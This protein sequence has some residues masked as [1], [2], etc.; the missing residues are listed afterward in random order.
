[1]LTFKEFVTNQIQMAKGNMPDF[2]AGTANKTPTPDI[3]YGHAM[4]PFISTK[5]K[6]PEEVAKDLE[7]ERQRLRSKLEKY[8]A[9]QTYV[10]QIDQL[11]KLSKQ[12]AI[13][14]SKKAITV[15]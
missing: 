13:E 15:P 14:Q 10:N 5:L 8:R 6:D 3:S 7:D 1:M 12:R 11:Q 2:I 4:N 9:H